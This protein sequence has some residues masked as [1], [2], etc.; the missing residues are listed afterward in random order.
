MASSEKYIIWKDTTG[1]A[2]PWH[3]EGGWGDTGTCATFD[4]AIA[5][6]VGCAK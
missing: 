2:Y 1:V 6:T 3:F 4:E 5:A